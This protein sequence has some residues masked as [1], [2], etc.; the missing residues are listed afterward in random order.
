MERFSNGPIPCSFPMCTL[1]TASPLRRDPQRG[2]EDSTQY[3]VRQRAQ[4]ESYSDDVRQRASCTGTRCVVGGAT[5]TLE[6][7]LDPSTDAELTKLNLGSRDGFSTWTG[8]VRGS[9][10]SATAEGATL[11]LSPTARSFGIWGQHGFAGTEIGGSPIS[12]RTQGVS[13]RGN[14]DYTASYVMGDAAGT[15]PSGIGSA[16]WRGIARAVST[17]TLDSQEGTVTVA[18][19]DLSVPRVDVEIESISPR[20]TLVYDDLPMANGS[21]QGRGHLQIGPGSTYSS[22]RINLSGNFY[23]SNHS[24]AYGVFNTDEHLGAFGAKR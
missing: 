19:P 8:T 16:T 7:L 6:E 22:S 11:N 21:F 2:G 23:G 3:D 9:L 5:I 20:G 14:L 24:E 12:G 13:F 4:G 15:N 17:R 10:E 18:I 1:N